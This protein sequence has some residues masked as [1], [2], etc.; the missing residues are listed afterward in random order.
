MQLSR[1]FQN[2]LHQTLV[3]F[4][5]AGSTDAQV[6]KLQADIESLKWIHKQELSEIKHNTGK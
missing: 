6:K 4:G 3:D 2:L 1:Y 5:N